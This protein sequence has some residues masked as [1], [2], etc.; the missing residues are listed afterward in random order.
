M[1]N[2]LK[3]K[4]DGFFYDLSDDLNDIKNVNLTLKHQFP[5]VLEIFQ[6]NPLLINICHYIVVLLQ[7]I[8][9]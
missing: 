2:C 8:S 7:M 5:F 1:A 3:K 6:N 9:L 4:R